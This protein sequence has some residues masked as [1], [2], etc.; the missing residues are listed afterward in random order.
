MILGMAKNAIHFDLARPAVAPGEV[1][2]GQVVLTI[3]A[4]QK[5]RGVF[6]SAAG[7]LYTT[8]PYTVN[9][10]FQPPQ[11]GPM[12]TRAESRTAV[13]KEDLFAGMPAVKLLDPAIM[14]HTEVIPPGTYALPFQFTIPPNAP[15]SWAGSDWWVLPR[16]PTDESAAADPSFRSP[17]DESSAE[18]PIFTVSDR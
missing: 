15:C 18:N 11:G 14:W 13:H 5:A 2:A 17:F 16:S 9:V 10:P 3:V 4:P 1:F 8:A 7:T 12:Q 6:V